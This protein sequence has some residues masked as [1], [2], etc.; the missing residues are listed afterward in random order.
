MDQVDLNCDLGESFGH[1]VIGND[2][3]VLPLI[4]SANVAC[5]F[6]AGD[7]SEMHR[8]VSRAKKNGV[9]IGA[10]P[11]LP[12]LEGFGRREMKVTPSEVYDMIVY[13][14]GA[15][16]AVAKAQNVSVNHVKPHG[17]LYHMASDQEEYAKAV[18]QAVADVNPDLLLFGMDGTF[19]TAAGEKAGLHVIYEAYADR[20][21]QP[22]GSLTP[23]S[24]PNALITNTD[25]ALKQVMQMLQE[26]TV[27][28]PVGEKTKVRAETICVHGDGTEAL[29]FVA[30]IRK[31]LQ[32]CGIKIGAWHESFGR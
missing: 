32:R 16:Q 20:T 7:F 31:E 10:H 19:L 9:A 5:G 1:Y 23:R 8:T 6:H 21:Y 27:T 28:T 2:E 15:L 17:A 11:G 13:Q 29:A 14:V 4:S 30:T 3:Q 24:L 22:D 25:Q 18:V 12:D 26:G